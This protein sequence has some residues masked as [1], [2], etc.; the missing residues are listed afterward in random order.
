MKRA[1]EAR[2]M[3]LRGRE[4]VGIVPS[5]IVGGGEGEEGSGSTV[6]VRRDVKLGRQTVILI[7]GRNPAPAT[8]SLR[9]ASATWKA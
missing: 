2:A 7:S 3:I 6:L 1:V 4:R 5:A 9:R 8:P